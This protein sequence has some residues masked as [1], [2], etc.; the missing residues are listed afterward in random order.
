MPVATKACAIVL[1][2]VGSRGAIRFDPKSHPAWLVAQSL[3]AAM[4]WLNRIKMEWKDGDANGSAVMALPFGR[5]HSA[6]CNRWQ[7]GFK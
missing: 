3:P 6:L 2:I 4:A 7:I 1:I 5:L